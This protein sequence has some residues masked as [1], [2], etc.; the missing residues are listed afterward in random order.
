MLFALCEVKH[1]NLLGFEVFELHGTFVGNDGPLTITGF[2]QAN[3]RIVI[4]AADT[5]VGYSEGQFIKAT[6]IDV[7][8]ETFEN[9]TTIYFAP[10]ANGSS[11]S[12]T[13]AGITDG[14]LLQTVVLVAGKK[15]L[16]RCEA[17]P[18]VCSESM[19]VDK[20]ETEW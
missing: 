6:G 12:L 7:V 4:L 20:T 9:S 14:D 10:D 1:R 3:D 8:Q 15:T 13:L 16:S 18:F 17:D 11:T 2:D 5:P 19:V